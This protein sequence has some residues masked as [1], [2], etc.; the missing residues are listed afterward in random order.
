MAQQR[1]AAGGTTLVMGAGS[2]I[3][4]AVARTLA[5]SASRLVV[6]DFDTTALQAIAG[7]LA[8]GPAEVL[9]VEVDVRVDSEVAAAVAVAAEDPGG[10]RS[11]CNC[12]GVEGQLAP[13]ADWTEEEWQRVIDVNLTGIWRCMRHQLEAM[14]RGAGGAIVNIASIFGLRGARGGSG[15]AAS[16]HGVIGLTRSAAL[17]YAAAGIRVNAVCPGPTDTPMM[18]RLV[19]ANPRLRAITLAG[20]PR[21]RWVPAEQVAA[22]VSWLCGP[23]AEA[24]TGQAISVDDGTSAG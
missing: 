23:G 11:A 4:A 16:K 1:E 18:Q 8:D 14:E 20:S 22:T 21:Q 3:G 19:V 9:A 15:Y 7:S 6:A 17:E 13:T 5:T 10:L 2:G 12:A 24:V